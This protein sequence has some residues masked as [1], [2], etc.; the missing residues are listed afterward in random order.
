MIPISFWKYFVW[1]KYCFAKW[2]YCFHQCIT[3][4]F[5][6]IKLYESLYSHYLSNSVILKWNTFIH[7][8]LFWKHVENIWDGIYLVLDILTLCQV[9]IELKTCF[10]KRVWLRRNNFLHV[11]NIYLENNHRVYDLELQLDFISNGIGIS[12]YITL[13][14]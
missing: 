7:M 5:T 3:L 6:S 2:L 1:F 4:T 12:W 13:L 9:T 10:G 8:G 14:F 11:E